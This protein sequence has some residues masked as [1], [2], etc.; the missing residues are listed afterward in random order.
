MSLYSFFYNLSA[1][2]PEAILAVTICAVLIGDMLVP[3]ARSRKATASMGMLGAVIAMLS[4]G[5]H[6]QNGLSASTHYFG[7]LMVMD[8]LSSVLKLVMIGGSALCIILG[9]GSNEFDGQRFG[10]FVVLVLG[11]CLGGCLLA[12]ANNLILFVVALE[13]LSLC[14]YALAGFVRASK[15][16][17][18]ASLKYVLFGAVAS[19]IMLF[20]LGYWYG[21]AGTVEIDTGV[22]AL[23][24]VSRAGAGGWVLGCVLLLV[25]SGVAF[26]IAAVPF[27][28]WCPDVYQGAPTPVTA[29]LSVVSKVGGFAALMRLV[30]PVVT[31]AADP[32]ALKV[33]IGLVAALT[34]TYGNLAAIRQVDVKRLLGYSSIAHAGYLLMTLAVLNQKALQ[35]SLIYLCIYVFM[36]LAAF[37]ITV[38]VINKRGGCEL[39]HFRG[40]A[41]SAPF[42]FVVM[43]TALVALT[44]LPPT[45]GFSGKFALFGVVVEAALN[46]QGSLSLFW[47]GLGLLG[48]LNSVVSL[49]YYMKIAKAMAFEAPE[50]CDVVVGSWD[51][52]FAFALMLP[53][54]ILLNFGPLV[55]LVSDLLA[56]ARALFL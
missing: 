10:E 14:A 47:W 18:E 40:I 35:A 1:L 55:S 6:P 20:G 24:T 43:F 31:A 17:A 25:G 56:P 34:M 53:L 27:H 49:F 51:R 33:G 4:I 9:R 41:L 11:V 16:A 5:L 22:A 42:L 29:F 8:Q 38:L 3:L 39:K 30:A 54:F 50:G 52:A 37:W 32:L 23:L 46:A 26:K 21:L 13:T 28:F 2:A 7:G 45:A 19:S 12:S 36:N 44:G 15:A 48:V